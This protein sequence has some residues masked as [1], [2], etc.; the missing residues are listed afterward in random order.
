[1]SQAQA[2]GWYSGMAALLGAVAQPPQ[3]LDV[4]LDAWIKSKR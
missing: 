1:L 4:Q 3:I 2:A